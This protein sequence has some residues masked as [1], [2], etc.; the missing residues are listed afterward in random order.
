MTVS[1]L[2]L[3]CAFVSQLH[4]TQALECGGGGDLLQ[5]KTIFS[6]KNT[7][8]G[9]VIICGKGDLDFSTEV[10]IMSY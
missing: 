3:I 1:N 2:N 9:D 10:I 7:N 4:E 5:T 8:F 6:L